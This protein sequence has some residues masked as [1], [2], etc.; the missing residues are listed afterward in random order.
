MKKIPDHAKRVFQGVIFDVYQWQ[1]EL[2]DGSIETFE[3]LRR[4]NTLMVI[5]TMGDTILLA[6][7]V[8]PGKGRF[9]SLFGGR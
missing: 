2:F 8:Q 1:Q 3:A 4:P 5:P 9:L 7:E 6:E